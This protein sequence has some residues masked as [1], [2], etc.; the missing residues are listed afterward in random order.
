M[1]ICEIC[2]KDI[3]E[4]KDTIRVIQDLGFDGI[5]FHHYHIECLRNYKMEVFISRIEKVY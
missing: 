4:L 5:L 3:Y 2:N 1:L